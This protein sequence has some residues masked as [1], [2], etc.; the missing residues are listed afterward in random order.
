MGLASRCKATLASPVT[1]PLF[2]MEQEESQHYQMLLQAIA[3]HRFAE[4]F[5]YRIG[6]HGLA[7]EDRCNPKRITSSTIRQSS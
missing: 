4:I 3:A 5:F 1:C 7:P 2:D 6:N